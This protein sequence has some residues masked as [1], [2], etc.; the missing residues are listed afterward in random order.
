M[1]YVGG[2]V[3]EAKRGGAKVERGSQEK[4]WRRV[5]VGEVG[6]G[7][8]TR[9]TRRKEVDGRR[10]GDRGEKREDEKVNEERES[11]DQG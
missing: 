8:G 10:G 7:G 2:G 4:V 1:A 6:R 11:R 3:I 5:G 9:R